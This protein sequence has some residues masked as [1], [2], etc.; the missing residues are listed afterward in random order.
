M[1]PVSQP[2]EIIFMETPQN[3]P[4]EGNGVPGPLSPE[5]PSGRAL[6]LVLIHSGGRPQVLLQAA[7]LM[8]LDGTLCGDFGLWTSAGS[9]GADVQTVGFHHFVISP[10]ATD[11]PHAGE[12]VEETRHV[13]PFFRHARPFFLR[14][15]LFCFGSRKNFLF[16]FA[17]SALFCF[18]SRKNFFGGENGKLRRPVRRGLRRVDARGSDRRRGIPR[19]PKLGD[20]QI[21]LGSKRAWGSSPQDPARHLQIH[22]NLQMRAWKNKCR[23]GRA[24]APPLQR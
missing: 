17:T 16:C 7:A 18:G 21:K 13:R 8:L 1:R 5:A 9:S 19:Y 14:R 11:P 4:M 24:P 3:M 20:G 22:N 15:K 10:G 6:P 23:R 2:A 12:T